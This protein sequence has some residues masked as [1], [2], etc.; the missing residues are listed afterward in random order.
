MR[1]YIYRIV[2]CLINSC[3][4]FYSLQ[5]GRETECE[6]LYDMV[7]FLP[8]LISSSRSHCSQYCR[9]MGSMT[10][11]HADGI[12]NNGASDKYPSGNCG[13]PFV[14]TSV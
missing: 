10:D 3:V 8:D 12:S 6:Q 5:G 13:L 2:A 14:R 7:D 1:G 11:R 4:E 9:R